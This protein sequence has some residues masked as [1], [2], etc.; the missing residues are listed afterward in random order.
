MGL[1]RSDDCGR[2]WVDTEI[3]RFSPLVYCRDVIVSPHD[4]KVMYSCLSPAAVSDDGS[5]YRSDD[6]GSSW[7]RIDHG[8]K[9]DSTMMTVI[10]H[11]RD[12]RQIYCATRNGQVFGTRDEGASW[13]EMRL[14]DG[15]HDAYALAVI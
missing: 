11:P 4:P 13:R 1:F 14:P 5:L 15:V 7:K 8:V 2:S 12:P 6:M 10:V 9:A 3:G